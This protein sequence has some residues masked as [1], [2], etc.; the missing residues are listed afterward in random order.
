[1]PDARAAAPEKLTAETARIPEKLTAEQLTVERG[2]TTKDFT[3]LRAYVQRIPP[4]VIARTYYDPGRRSARSDARRDGA[5]VLR[6][7]ALSDLRVD[8]CEAYK[9]FLK[10]PDP[11]FV[12]GCPA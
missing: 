3:A 2:Y 8:D 12:C 6:G 5:V 11:R 4:A 9:D 1:M 10:N 7:K